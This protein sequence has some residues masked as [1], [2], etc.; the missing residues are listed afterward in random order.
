MDNDPKHITKSTQEKRNEI[1]FKGRASQRTL[2]NEDKNQV[3]KTQTLA[4]T[5]NN[6]S[7][8]L[9]RKT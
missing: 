6:C 5:E 4:E 3:R 2:L 7:K 8:I 1:L 9:A